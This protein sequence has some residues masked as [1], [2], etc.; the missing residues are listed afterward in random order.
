MPTTLNARWS[1]DNN[2]IGN[3]NDQKYSRLLTVGT[4]VLV[5][6]IDSKMIVLGHLATKALTTCVPNALSNITVC[7]TLSRAANRSYCCYFGQHISYYY[8]H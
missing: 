1:T 5:Q 6:R 4:I 7:C 2:I 8:N 3:Y